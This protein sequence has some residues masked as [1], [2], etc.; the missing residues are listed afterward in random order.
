MRNTEVIT[1]RY[2]DCIS[3]LYK[4]FIRKMLSSR[5][6]LTVVPLLM[7]WH[8]HAIMVKRNITARKQKAVKSKNSEQNIVVLRGSHARNSAVKLQEKL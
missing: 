1:S 4:I 8:K 5:P 3:V 6:L 2:Q 7:K